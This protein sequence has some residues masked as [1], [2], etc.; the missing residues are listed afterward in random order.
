MT[1]QDSSLPTAQDGNLCR[2]GIRDFYGRMLTI[3]DTPGFD[4]VGGTGFIIQNEIKHSLELAAPG[5]HAFLL[6][7]EFTSESS[8]SEEDDKQFIELIINTFGHE[9]LQYIVFIFTN[10]EKLQA[11]KIDIEQYW[12]NHQSPSITELMKKCRNRYVPINND[13]P[14]N[15]KDASFAELMLI[16]DR[17]LEDN[18]GQEYP[19]RAN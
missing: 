1:N 17:M 10:I 9:L 12:K 13:A 3:V 14:L 7:L 11:N 18:G 19:C 2:I 15:A 8:F 4:N 6:V 16:I 5:P